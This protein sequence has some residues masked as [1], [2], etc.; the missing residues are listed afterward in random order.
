VASDCFL[1]YGPLASEKQRCAAHLL[2]TWNEIERS[3]TRAAMRFSRRVASLLR[4]AMAVK[5]CG[6]AL[7][8]PAYAVAPHRLHAGPDRLLLGDSIDPNEVR[9]IRWLPSNAT[10]GCGS[11]TTTRRRR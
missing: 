9:L 5:R 6:A 7:S 11:S 1:A 3:K 2:K 8:P 4:R 10:T